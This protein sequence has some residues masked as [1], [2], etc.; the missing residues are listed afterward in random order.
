M[1]K[2]RYIKPATWNFSSNGCDLFDFREILP[3]AAYFLRCSTSFYLSILYSF[4][5]VEQ[6]NQ[7]QVE[8]ST[9]DVQIIL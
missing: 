5:I 3:E 8:V 4:S 9:T 7:Q 6:F 1:L 2:S